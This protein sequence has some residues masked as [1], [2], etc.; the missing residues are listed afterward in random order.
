MAQDVARA[1]FLDAQ[2]TAQIDEEI[3]RFADEGTAELAYDHEVA[4]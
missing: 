3:V 4:G 2:R 1:A